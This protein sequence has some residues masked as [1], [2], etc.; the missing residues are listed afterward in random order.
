[1]GDVNWCVVATSNNSI[2]YKGTF[3]A[4]RGLPFTEFAKKVPLYKEYD[5]AY[6]KEMAVMTSMNHPNVLRPLAVTRDEK[7]APAIL[8]EYFPYGSVLDWM[9]YAPHLI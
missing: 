8:M 5:R 3:P 1:M 7:A 2:V 6:E 9:R 4:A